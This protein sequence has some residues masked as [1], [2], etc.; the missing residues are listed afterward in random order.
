MSE[1]ACV[2]P[3]AAASVDNL[4]DMWKALCRAQDALALFYER[5]KE[6]M[7]AA[8]DINM[9]PMPDERADAHL[10]P[11]GRA[12][13]VGVLPEAAASDDNLLAMRQEVFQVKDALC[14]LQKSLLAHMP[15]EPRHA[16]FDSYEMPGERAYAQLAPQ[17]R[18]WHVGVPPEAAAS[19]DNLLAMRHALSRVKDDLS[20]LAQMTEEPMRAAFKSYEAPMPDECADA[21]LA[22]QGRAWHVGVPPEAAASDDNLLAM[23]DDAVSRVYIVLWELQESLCAQM[24]KEPMHAAFGSYDAP[25]PDERADA[26]L[27]P[28]GRACHVGGLD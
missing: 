9:A 20:L 12:W 6:P 7:H 21:Q 19:V 24:T 26:Q 14:W 16:A 13:H 2:P 17:G 1:P 18:A 5:T 4:L 28:Q 23:R 8:F 27:A 25:M 11:Q 10:A 22:P 15:K 3:E